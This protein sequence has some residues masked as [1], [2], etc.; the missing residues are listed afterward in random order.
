MRVL[1][2]GGTGY[3]GSAIV[4]ACVRRG[5]TPIVFARH[6][7]ER[8]IH[9]VEAISGDLR[10]EKDVAAAVGR[11]DAVCHTGALVSIWR[12]RAADFDE[13]NVEG[14]RHVLDA[15]RAN[16]VARLVY[17]ASFLALPPSGRT[18]PIEANDYQRTKRR[19]LDLVREAARS[20][21]PIVTLVPG[22][23]YGP[24]ARTEGNLVARLLD[25]HRRGALPG[26]AG[27]ERIWSFAWIDHVADAHVAALTRGE[28]GREYALGGENLPQRRLFDI[29]RELTGQPLPRRI[30]L[31]LARLA[32]AAEEARVR[33]FGGTPLLT[34]GVVEIFSH[35]WPLDSAAASADLGYERLP[36]AA[37]VARILADLGVI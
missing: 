29:V 35:D 16:G 32:G 12:P 9:P 19:A 28:A 22:V 18:T 10:S 23:V 6:A 15:C 1:V 8:R 36:L 26:I 14:T 5:L 30:P 7:Y 34:R 27:G 3:L 21:L 17:T 20:G 37:G 11:A 2:T 13:I 24:G 33:V 4:R 25:D 31:S